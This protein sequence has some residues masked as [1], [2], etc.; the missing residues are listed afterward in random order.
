MVDHGTN[1]TGTFDQLT[2]VTDP[3]LLTPPAR[4]WTD[5]EWQGIRAGY[6]SHDMDNKWDAF[7]EGNRLYLHR[8][9]TGYGIYEVQF[10]CDG[11]AWVISELLVCGTTDRYRR[12]SDAFQ[13]AQVDGLIDT[14]LLG[15]SEAP[16]SRDALREGRFSY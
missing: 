1:N 6:E 7:V 4:R 14:V 2:P 5:S 9:W 8:S 15:N 12:G 16:P 3:T 10:A 11:D 13:V